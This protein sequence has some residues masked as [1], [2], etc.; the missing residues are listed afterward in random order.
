MSSFSYSRIYFL[1][2]N[3]FIRKTILSIYLVVRFGFNDT[4][5]VFLS[6]IEKNLNMLLKNSL[7]AEQHSLE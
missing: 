5:L 6:P 7:R 2:S 4:Q 3:L 1:H